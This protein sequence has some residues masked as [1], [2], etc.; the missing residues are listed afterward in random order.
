M[1]PFAAVETESNVKDPQ[2]GQSLRYF[3]M[4][5]AGIAQ[6]L[7]DFGYRDEADRLF[8]VREDLETKIAPLEELQVPQGMKGSST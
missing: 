6:A 1:E 8:R 3:L 4:S 2:Q 7:E 5:L